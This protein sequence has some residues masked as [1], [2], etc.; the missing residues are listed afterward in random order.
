MTSTTLAEL[1]VE[2]TA[3]VESFQRAIAEHLQPAIE[4]LQRELRR[5]YNSLPGMPYTAPSLWDGS[6][7]AADRGAGDRLGEAIG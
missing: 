6:Q 7:M 2:L 1:T 4:G 3:N 5:W